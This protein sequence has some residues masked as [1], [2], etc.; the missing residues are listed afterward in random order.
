MTGT[1]VGLIGSVVFAWPFP[2][3]VAPPPMKVNGLYAWPVWHD[4]PDWMAPGSWQLGLAT[5]LAGAAMGMALLRGIRF[6]FGLGRGM[7]GLGIGDADLFMMAG[8]FVGWQVIL[9]AFFVSVFPGLVF[10][11]LQMILRGDKP[12]PFGPSLALGVMLTLLTWPVLGNHLRP[13]LTNAALLATM[14][15]LGAVML[16]AVSFL[17]R[18]VRG[19]PDVEP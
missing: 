6:L 2:E 1:V 13:H 18:V 14:G 16:L 7:E 19:R 4:L 12:L 3:V 11:I 15:T 5:G 10:G 8:A 9:I 17:L